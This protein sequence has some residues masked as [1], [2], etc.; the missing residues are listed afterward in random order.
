VRRDLPIR[1]P[2]NDSCAS[3]RRFDCDG[4]PDLD[5][6]RLPGHVNNDLRALVRLYHDLVTPKSLNMCAAFWHLPRLHSD[7]TATRRYRC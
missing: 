6:S 4:H 5:P 3:V 1:L 7:I 2:V